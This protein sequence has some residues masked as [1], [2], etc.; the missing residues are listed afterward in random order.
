MQTAV[1]WLGMVVWAK[2]PY[3]LTLQYITRHFILQEKY[4]SQYSWFYMKF[5]PKIF[6]NC[7]HAV[8]P[9]LWHIRKKIKYLHF[10][11]P[12]FLFGTWTQSKL[13][14]FLHQ[15]KV[16]RFT[17]ISILVYT[18]RLIILYMLH[19]ITDKC[20]IIKCYTIWSK[21]KAKWIQAS[22]HYNIQYY[23]QIFIMWFDY[24]T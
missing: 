3:N 24:K 8:M 19:S 9:T 23:K 20:T 11:Y 17:D 14:F 7:Y 4:I 18:N 21:K 1:F 10:N 22:Q 12:L 5:N 13:Y 2:L 15:I 16:Q 6:F